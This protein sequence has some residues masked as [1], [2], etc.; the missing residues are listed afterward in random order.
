ML[1]SLFVFSAVIDLRQ[2]NKA[3]FSMLLHPNNEHR[4]FMISLVSLELDKKI[5]L[6]FEL[7]HELDEHV[8]DVLL[9][10]LRLVVVVDALLRLHGVY[11]LLKFFDLL[12]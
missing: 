3:S 5:L 8:F 7:L 6:D 10:E 9:L 4:T 1:L 2:F 12:K 11:F